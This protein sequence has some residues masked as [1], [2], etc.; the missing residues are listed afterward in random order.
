MQKTVFAAST[1]IGTLLVV[2]LS[3]SNAQA[4]D[5]DLVPVNF[6]FSPDY[7]VQGEAFDIY[8]EVINT[9]VVSGSFIIGLTEATLYGF[10]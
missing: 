10:N 3:S 7:P 2:L 8:F 6:T 5:T 1:I 4:I 9:E